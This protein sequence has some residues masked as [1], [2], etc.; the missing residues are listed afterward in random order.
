MA[1]TKEQ[2]REI[3]LTDE[4]ED[5][6]KISGLPEYLEARWCA[7]NRLPQ[8]RGSNQ[9]WA[10]PPSDVLGKL[11]C[12]VEVGPGQVPEVGNLRLQVRPK[13]IGI[14]RRELKEKRNRKAELNIKGQIVQE[15]KDQH[16]ELTRRGIEA[17]INIRDKGH[18]FRREMVETMPKGT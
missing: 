8:R 7:K 18:G 5:V 14:K 16:E 10:D 2:I 6:L 3:E 17:N 4:P 12:G 9:R 15:A 11:H 13:A 1:V